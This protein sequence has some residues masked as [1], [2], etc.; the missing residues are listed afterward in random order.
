MVHRREIVQQ[1]FRGKL[2][3]LNRENAW[4]EFEMP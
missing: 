1:T 2:E 3:N 4:I